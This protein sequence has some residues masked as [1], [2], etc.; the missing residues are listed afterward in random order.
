MNLFLDKHTAFRARVRQFVEQRLTPYADEWER[1]GA[2]PRSLFLEMAREGFL[3]LT[4]ER[5]YGGQ[6]LDFGYSVVLAE[7]LARS[8][9]MGLT[10]SLLAQVHI[11]PPLLAALGSEEQK[12]DFLAPALRGEMIGALASTE[13]AGGSDIVRAIQCTAE[14]DG[15]FWVVTGEKKYITNGP[16]ADFVIVLARTRR[17]RTTTSLSLVIVPTDTAGFRVKETLR[18]LGM[19]SSP[20]GW[21]E[22][23][24]CRVPRRF[25]LGKPNLGFFYV[26]RNILEERLIGGAVSVSIATLVLEETIQYLQRRTAFNGTL[27]RLQAIRHHISEVAAEIEMAKRFVH[28]VAENY[29]D[30]TIEAKEI[31]MIKFLVA[32]TTQRVVG[33]CLQFQGGEGFL[34][35]NWMTRVYRDARF[36]SVGGGASEL[37]KDLVAS[38]LRL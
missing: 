20:T 28:S 11:F 8:R 7:E 15:D 21:L 18:K 25:T 30:G 27:S 29:R 19:K 38:Y 33:R 10:L 22:F 35:D 36:L 5:R 4:H 16:I 17:E 6:E 26:N 14:E 12:R 24:H 23:D 9:M 2:F 3:G 31:C 34:D 1:E 13:P 37:M 32:E